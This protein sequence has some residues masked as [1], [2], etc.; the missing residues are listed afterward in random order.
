MVVDSVSITLF[1]NLCYHCKFIQYSK[2]ADVQQ[3]E[4]FN[5]HH[6]YD[7]IMLHKI[8]AAATKV[9]GMLLL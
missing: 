2:E 8:V 5:D 6:Y 3:T 4:K 1:T 9:L 7:E